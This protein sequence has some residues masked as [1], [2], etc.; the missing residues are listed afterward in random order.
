MSR[1]QK[2]ELM[3][4]YLAHERA[5]VRRRPRWT[6]ATVLVRLRRW[7]QTFIARPVAGDK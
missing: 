2:H 6:V 1:K 5:L 3:L 7:V 4:T